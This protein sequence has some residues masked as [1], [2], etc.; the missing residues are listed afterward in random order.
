MKPRTEKMAKP[1][2]TEV[3]AL[4]KVTIRVSLEKI[5]DTD[6]EI[7]LLK[8]EIQILLAGARGDA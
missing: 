4:P 6:T 7:K 1:A 2:K 8:I 5:F 3:M